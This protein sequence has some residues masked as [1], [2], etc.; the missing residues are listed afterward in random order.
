MPSYRRRPLL[1]LTELVSTYIVRIQPLFMPFRCAAHGPYQSN[2]IEA[3]HSIK[4]HSYMVCVFHARRYRSAKDVRP[5]KFPELGVDS[6]AKALAS[7]VGSRLL[8]Q[9][10]AEL[11]PWFVVSLIHHTNRGK[12]FG[13]YHTK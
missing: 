8:S 6:A 1:I 12:S 11:E 9:F 10:A 13:I 3:L 5:A 2:A 4:A 7:R